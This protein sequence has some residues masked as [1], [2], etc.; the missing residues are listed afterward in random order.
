VL[1]VFTSNS[2]FKKTQKIS[3]FEPSFFE[4]FHNSNNAVKWLNTHITEFDLMVLH[5]VWTLLFYRYVRVAIKNKVDYMF[6]PHGSL[7]AFDPKKKTIFKKIL[8]RL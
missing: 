6:W 3:L 2:D 8:R 1:S 5:G 7:D 4:R